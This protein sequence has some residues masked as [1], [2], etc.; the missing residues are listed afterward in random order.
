[1]AAKEQGACAMNIASRAD[2]NTPRIPDAGEHFMV[3]A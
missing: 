3:M 2:A 1:V